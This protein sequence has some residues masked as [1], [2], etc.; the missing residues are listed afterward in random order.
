MKQWAYVVNPTASP[1]KNITVM[2]AEERSETGQ[3]QIGK[4]YV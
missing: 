1:G 4:R 3:L 2:L